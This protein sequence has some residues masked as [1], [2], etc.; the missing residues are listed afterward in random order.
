[1]S[2]QDRQGAR[3]ASELVQRYNFGKSFAEVMGFATEAQEA[4]AEA[5]ASARAANEAVAS[6]DQKEIFN[7]LTNNGQAQ[8]IYRD[9]DTGEIYINASYLATGIIKAI[10]EATTINLATGEVFI[11]SERTTNTGERYARLVLHGGII[12]SSGWNSETEEYIP[13][14]YISPGD[15]VQ[16]YADAL[17]RISSRETDLTIDANGSH[18]V[19]VGIGDNA[20]TLGGKTNY[21]YGQQVYIP[22]NLRIQYKDVSWK[23]NGDGTYTLIGR[24]PTT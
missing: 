20:V 16:G 22:N 10:N 8:G 2:K 13:A 23:D 18:R 1:M 6:L 12:Q 7:R 15:Y 11:N 9:P 17:S 19:Q 24:T 21:I 5:N 14:I 4:A 3:T